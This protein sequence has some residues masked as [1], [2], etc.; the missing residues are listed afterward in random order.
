MAK[1]QS[2]IFATFFSF[3]FLVVVN[4]SSNCDSFTATGCTIDAEMIEETYV[5]LD[6]KSC[7]ERCK[8]KLGCEFYR[9]EHMNDVNNMSKCELLKADYCQSCLVIGGEK[10]IDLEHCITKR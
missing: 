9:W 8:D 10:D 1:T 4:G 5:G 7:Q 2:C 6:E 3:G